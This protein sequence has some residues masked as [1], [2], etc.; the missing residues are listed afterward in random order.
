MSKIE[1][2]ERVLNSENGGLYAVIGGNLLAF[3]LDRVLKSQYTVNAKKKTLSI[4]PAAAQKETEEQ[5][6]ELKE[7]EG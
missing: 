3:S 7:P 1:L 4:A 6:A 2:F 5:Q